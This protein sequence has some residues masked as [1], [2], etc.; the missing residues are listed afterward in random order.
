MENLIYKTEENRLLKQFGNGLS[1]YIQDHC[2][3]T[4]TDDGYRI[5][6]TPNLVHSTAGSV[7]WGGLVLNPVAAGVCTFIKGHTY[8][9]AF[10]VKGKSSKG[11]S[12]CGWSNQ[13]GWGGGGLTPEPSDTDCYNPVV[14]NFNGEGD[15]W[16]K[17]TMNDDLYKKCTTSYSGFVAGNTYL[18]YSGFKFG[19]PYQNTGSDGTDLYITNIRMYDITDNPDF[20]ISK[21]GVVSGGQLIEGPEMKI[22]ETKDLIT[23]NF[24]EI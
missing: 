10:H 11:A 24:I 13:V 4:L 5:Y 16:Y 8:V 1:R 3:V 23:T 17:W 18:S 2:Q 7:M 14:D 6:R 9:F 22:M 12:D 20:D 19:F 21:D 15:F